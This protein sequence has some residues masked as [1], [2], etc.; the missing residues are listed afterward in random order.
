MKDVLQIIQKI[1]KAPQYKYSIKITANFA[2]YN[3]KYGHELKS[4][5]ICKDLNLSKKQL[6]KIEAGD[7]EI[8]V[9]D[10]CKVND[11]IKNQI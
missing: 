7:T 3:A 2:K 1:R 11:Y 5:K 8:S 6:D 10:Y 4:S 9:K